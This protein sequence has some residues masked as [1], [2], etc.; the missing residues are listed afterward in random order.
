MTSWNE[1]EELRRDALG[2]DVLVE[3]AKA[4]A[5]KNLRASAARLA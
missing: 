3:G 5:G 4:G 2:K 1:A